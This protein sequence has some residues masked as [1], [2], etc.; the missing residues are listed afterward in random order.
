MHPRTASAL[1]LALLAASA[2]L[3]PA[4]AQLSYADLVAGLSD[5]T[6]KKAGGDGR[7]PRGQAG[8]RRRGGRRR[9]LRS[10]R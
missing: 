7:R 5:D 6:P 10:R 4:R 8:R 3:T 1:L 9:A 2:L